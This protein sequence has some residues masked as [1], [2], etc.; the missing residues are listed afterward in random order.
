M[1]ILSVEDRNLTLTQKKSTVDDNR[2]HTA[3]QLSG[4]GKNV[5]I[6]R[7]ANIILY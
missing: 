2:Y 5:G 7:T 6:Y 4:F 3:V 1:V